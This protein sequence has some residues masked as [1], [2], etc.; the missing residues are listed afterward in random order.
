MMIFA[1]CAGSRLRIVIAEL[2]RVLS[3]GPS[4]PE[5]EHIDQLIELWERDEYTFMSQ[6]MQEPITHSGGLIDTS[7]FE[8]LRYF[9][10]P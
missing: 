10:I 3:I 4:W 5:M 1:K 2:L 6:G 9:A 7:W 8:S